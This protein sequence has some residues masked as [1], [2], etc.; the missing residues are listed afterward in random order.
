MNKTWRQNFLEVIHQAFALT[1]HN[2]GS[3]KIPA[4]YRQIDLRGSLIGS[5]SHNNP[6][7]ASIGDFVRNVMNNSKMYFQDKNG[8]SIAYPGL[9]V[10]YISD[11]QY[12]DLRVDTGAGSSSMQ[13]KVESIM[14]ALGASSL[15]NC[16]LIGI[17][18]TDPDGGTYYRFSIVPAKPCTLNVNRLGDI[19]Y[20]Y[21][22]LGS[23][24]QVNYNKE[25]H[26]LISGVTGSGKSYMLE[27]LLGEMVLKIKNPQH[28]GG[29]VYVADP[30]FSDLA[31]YA[32]IIGVTEVAQTPA[33]IAGILREATEAMN[34]RYKN[35]PKTREALGKTALDLG[36]APIFIVIDEFSALMAATTFIKQGKKLQEEINGYLTELIQ[37]GRQATVFL[38]LAMQRASTDAG[39]SSN[40]RYNFSTKVILGNSDATTVSMLFGSQKDNQ[41]PNIEQVGGGYYEKN[42]GLLPRKFFAWNYSVN[43]MIDVVTN[44]TNMII[45][46]NELRKEILQVGSLIDLIDLKLAQKRDVSIDWKVLADKLTYLAA[47]SKNYNRNLK[48]VSELAKLDNP[49]LETIRQL[50]DRIGNDLIY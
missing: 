44:R 27:Q 18:Q 4:G 33:Q 6:F 22:S 1:L 39:L 35:M 15:F 29:A 37:K 12:M 36:Y 11:G 38:V 49:N 17:N 21:L 48:Y 43:E 5:R 34:K 23:S 31:Q 41:L 26:L 16:P 46:K 50:I 19:P 10:R 42:D 8:Y 47:N 45:N 24:L 2:Q 9:Y 7:E 3:Q 13:S 25:P 20:E 30:K 40:I 32:N 14:T 28:H